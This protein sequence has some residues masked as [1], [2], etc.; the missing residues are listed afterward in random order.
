MA[1]RVTAADVARLAK[2]ST[3]TVS[4]VVN[5][6]DVHITPETREAVLK[7]IKELNYRPNPLGVALQQGRTRSIGLVSANPGSPLFAKFSQ[8]VQEGA[9]QRGYVVSNYSGTTLE[10]LTGSIDMLLD[11]SIDGV[12]AFARQL[13]PS[14]TE[15]LKQGGVPFVLINDDGRHA[16]PDGSVNFDDGAA[17]TEA[18]AHLFHNGYRTLAYLDFPAWHSFPRRRHAFLS[19]LG[20]LGGTGAIVDLTRTEIADWDVG[21][22]ALRHIRARWDLPVGVIAFNDEFALEIIAAAQRSGLRVPAD[23][24]VIG[25]NADF[26]E[27]ISHPRLTTIQPPLKE[28]AAAALDGLIK[29]IEDAEPEPGPWIREFPCQL[30]VRESCGARVN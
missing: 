3:A 6:K 18:T 19:T 14:V 16:D 17:I 26:P 7:A 21:S 2:V 22:A 4:Y 23:V 27:H 10:H 15:R 29:L 12:I 1:R 25:F 13:S 9:L 8:L 30:L 28:Q 20:S 24:A 11:R 5:N